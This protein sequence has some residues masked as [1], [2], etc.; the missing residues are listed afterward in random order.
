[1]FTSR[2]LNIFKP[3]LPSFTLGHTSTIFFACENQNSDHEFMPNC[4]ATL[5]HLTL[6]STTIHRKSSN[7][8]SLLE[9]GFSFAQFGYDF[10]SVFFS[11]KITFNG[12]W[13]WPNC[14]HFSFCKYALRKTEGFF[15]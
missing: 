3:L 10:L 9:L 12:S 2:I 4:Q 5:W 14:V 15:C 7:T 13:Q 6:G 11:H 1:M 8:K